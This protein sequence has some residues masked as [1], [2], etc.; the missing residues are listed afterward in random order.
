MSNPFN[1]KIEDIVIRKFNGSQ[2]MSIMPQVAELVI[3]QSIFAPI[4]KAQL[5]IQDYVNLLDNF[6]IVGEETVEITLIQ[7]TTQNNDQRIFARFVISAIHNIEVAS[8]NRELTYIID[9]VS[10]ESFKNAK[11][12][13]SHRYNE[14]IEE[15]IGSILKDYLK[16]DKLYTTFQDT[17]VAR[18]LVI[19][20]IRPFVAIE[21][22]CKHAISKDPVA[23][24]THLFYETL[25]G[26]QAGSQGIAEPAFTFKS[27]QRPTWKGFQDDA[28]LQGAKNNSYYYISNVELL[29]NPAIA[30]ALNAQGINQDRLVID[31]KFNKKYSTLEKILA[32][33]FENEYVEVNPL[34]KDHLIT[35]TTVREPWTR[36]S[37]PYL[38]TDAYIDDVI[39]D[40]TESETSPRV[41]YI[42]NSY[43]NQTDPSRR[44]KFGRSVRSH[45]AFSQIDLQIG[46]LTD[47]TMRPGDVIYVGLP[48]FHGFN[49]VNDNHFITGYFFISEVKTIIRPSGETSTLL[50]INKDSFEN[51]I[52][53]ASRFNLGGGAGAGTGGTTVNTTTPS[54]SVRDSE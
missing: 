12:K 37:V 10:Y 16:T 5:L 32:G 11:T 54:S 47:L 40:R 6:P 38:N 19:P 53:P 13:V 44:D 43:S 45:A 14:T 41:R 9:L 30:A 48:E 50:H 20:N 24:H 29:K 23:Y 49:E 39:N 34:Q 18:D 33:Y 17:T 35:R 22:L 46:I 27:M 21:W 7:G 3:Y 31:I 8:T 1:A 25:S 28:A 2:N 51:P 42:I 15:T 26:G 52:F 4:I 36:L